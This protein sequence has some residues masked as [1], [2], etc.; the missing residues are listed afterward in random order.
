MD[1]VIEQAWALLEIDV[2]QLKET[3]GIAMKFIV[4][5]ADSFE[6]YLM[7][8]PE[9]INSARAKSMM[10]AVI[11]EKVKEKHADVVMVVSDAWIAQ[12][13]STDR[14]TIDRIDAMGLPRAHELGLVEKKE[15]LIC[16]INM[17]DSDEQAMLT[18]SYDRS[19]DE[20][21]T[22]GKREMKRGKFQGRLSTFFT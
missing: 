6:F 21:I 22:M 2:D 9:D 15:A 3:G 10:A 5:S 19:Q 1:E 14:K 11:R 12:T 7:P 13:S 18:W 16:K 4:T 20:T 8:N 17:R